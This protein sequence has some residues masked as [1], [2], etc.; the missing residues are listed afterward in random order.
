MQRRQRQRT[1]RQFA[2][3]IVVAMLGSIGSEGCHDPSA[4]R[5]TKAREDRIQRILTRLE[6]QEAR[7]PAKVRAAKSWIEDQYRGDV[8]QTQ[9]NRRRIRAWNADAEAKWAERAPRHRQLWQTQ[10]ERNPERARRM[11]IDMLY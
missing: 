1:Q 2:S 10:W 5:Q 3:L 4:Q 11:A 6:A 8:A 9:A 7:R